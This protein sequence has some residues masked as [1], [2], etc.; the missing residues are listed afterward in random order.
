MKR[1]AKPRAMMR[2]RREAWRNVI[3][4]TETLFSSTEGYTAEEKR[5]RAVME[6]A[7]RSARDADLKARKG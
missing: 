2:M 4:G 6:K 1:P 7:V 5:V 3:A